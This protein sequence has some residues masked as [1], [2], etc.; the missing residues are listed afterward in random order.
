MPARVNTT[1]DIGTAKDAS[2]SYDKDNIYLT[3]EG[4]VYRH[5]KKADQ[6]EYWDEIIVAGEV[7]PTLT[8]DG[9]ANAPVDDIYEASPNFE[10]GDGT[11]D[12]EYSSTPVAPPLTGPATGVSIASG[13][14]GYSTASAVATSGGNG[15]GL[16]VDITVT[17]DAIT[18]AI[19]NSG[20]TGY[21]QGDT[22]TVAG[23]TGGT[24]TVSI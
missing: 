5:F 4:W 3:T 24:L 22:V 13:G 9:V 21:Q 20:G 1:G 11:F 7:D 10:V 16:T 12:F 15:N 14:S 2:D 18:G 19:L 23:G 8:I 17:G 6:S